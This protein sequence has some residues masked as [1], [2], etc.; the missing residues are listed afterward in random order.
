MSQRETIR[1]MSFNI[2][3][4]AADDGAERWGLRKRLVV[5]RVADAAPH[6]LGLQE[7][8]D[9]AQARFV[10][11]K[12][13]GYDFHGTRRDPSWDIE[14]AP[15]LVRRSAFR[16]IRAGH[17]WLSRTPDVVGSKNWGSA[18]A[19]TASWVEACH[20][21]TGRTLVFVNTHLDYEPAATA[22][23][24]AVLRRWID[25]AYPDTP[26][27]VTGDFNAIKESAAYRQLVGGPGGLRDAFRSARTVRGDE[28]TYHEYGTIDP[29]PI[30]WILVSRHFGVLDAAVD[31]YREGAR[32]PSD[33]YPLLATLE[34]RAPARRRLGR[35]AVL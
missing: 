1:V 17:F 15:A 24:A 28:G 22:K 3:Y 21:V 16:P 4:G 8:Y 2:R 13:P 30:D 14:M 25:R 26:I 5:A 31:R 18:F 12:F 10:R 20:R 7:C 19:R 29:R 9:D 32:Y 27:V 34:W 23:S 6:L 35:R 11:R 33:H